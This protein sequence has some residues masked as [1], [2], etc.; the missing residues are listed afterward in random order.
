MSASVPADLASALAARYELRGVLGRGGMATVYRAFDFKHRRDVAVKVLRPEVA[1]SLGADRFLAEIQ[2][3]A[4]LTHPHILPLHDSGESEGFVY[5]VSPLIEGGSLRQR[6]E[7]NARYDLD[8]TIDI[9]S[10]IADALSYAHRMGVVHRDIK[11]ENILFSQGHPVVA[12][13]GIAKA[14]SSA[15]GRNLTRTGVSLGTPGYMS[16]EQ[17]AGFHEPDARTD[18]FSLAVVVYEMLIGEIPGC[19]PSEAAVRARTF[20]DVPPAHRRLLTAAGSTVEAAL[21]HAMAIRQEDRTPTPEALIDELRGRASSTSRRRYQ[22]DE[23][24]EIIRRASE[25]EAANPT[26]SGAMTI[27]GVEAIAAEVG[28]APGLV[29]S[30]AASVTPSETAAAVMLIE[31]PKRNAFIGGPT[32][33]LVQRVVPGELRESDFPRLVDEI[34]RAFQN[35][36]YVSQLGRSMTWSMSRGSAG[37]RDVDVAI[38]VGDGNTRIVVEETLWGMIGGIFGGLGG[39]LGGG[40]TGP[41][42]ATVVALHAAPALPIVLPIWYAGVFVLAR[43]SFQRLA[44][45]RQREL[46]QTA[47]RLA[48][49][50]AHLIQDRSV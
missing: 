45:R 41:I 46:E 12:D 37:R 17:A 33:V 10:R 26:Q 39:G 40:G 31:P 1:A 14:L 34:R 44:R 28:I 8:Q 2:T 16:P 32:R 21:V 43:T 24:D 30:A 29:R 5:Y 9:A 20:T 35:V 4:R 36:G 48:T 49:T 18:V 25:L 6:L 7:Q 3:V 15:S 19:W 23:V 22:A 42:I 27:G 13:F 47:D 50:A 38:S 11:P